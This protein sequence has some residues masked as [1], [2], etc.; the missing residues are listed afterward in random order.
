MPPLLQALL[1]N[2]A[3]RKFVVALRREQGTLWLGA[4]AAAM[5]SFPSLERTYTSA[6][7]RC[8]SPRC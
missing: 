2:P 8:G 1:P 4:D 7:T 6:V 5:P 3:D